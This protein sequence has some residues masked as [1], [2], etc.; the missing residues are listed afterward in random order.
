MIGRVS[1]LLLC[2]SLSK[3][4]CCTNLNDTS[5]C[6][7]FG[8][9]LWPSSGQIVKKLVRVLSIYRHAQKITKCQERHNATVIMTKEDYDTKLREML[10]TS[11]YKR[12]KG[13]PVTAQEGRVTH[14]LNT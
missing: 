4:S 10:N 9:Q 12:M 2:I 8:Q 14:R 13:D 1:Y 11:T 7:R 3:L 6:Q 5:D